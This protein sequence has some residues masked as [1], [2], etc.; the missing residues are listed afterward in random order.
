MKKIIQIILMFV[1]VLVLAVQ[2]SCVTPPAAIDVPSDEIRDTVELLDVIKPGAKPLAH[3]TYKLSR[4]WVGTLTQ[5][6]DK[7][8]ETKLPP[9]PPETLRFNCIHVLDDGR[10]W[11]LAV[12]FDD[13]GRLPNLGAQQFDFMRKPRRSEEILQT[14]NFDTLKSRFED[15]VEYNSGA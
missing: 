8:A 2:N 13:A 11:L 15:F 12:R 9:R 4:E 3:G 14:R 10:I 6:E 1:F 7:Q 5:I